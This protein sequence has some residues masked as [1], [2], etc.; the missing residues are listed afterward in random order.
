MTEDPRLAIIANA[1]GTRFPFPNVLAADILAALNAHDRAQ[2][3]QALR[4]RAELV[5]MVRSAPI[6]SAYH[7]MNGFESDRLIE[8]YERWRVGCRALLARIDGGGE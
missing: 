6:M 5:G 8:D 4:E 1:I 7:G 3:E 2:S